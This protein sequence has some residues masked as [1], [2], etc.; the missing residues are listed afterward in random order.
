MPKPEVTTVR[1]S[2]HDG[3]SKLDEFFRQVRHEAA[4]GRRQWVLQYQKSEAGTVLG[5]Q[6]DPPPAEE[7]EAAKEE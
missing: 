5:L 4:H 7:K 6:L 1:S 3:L 2:E